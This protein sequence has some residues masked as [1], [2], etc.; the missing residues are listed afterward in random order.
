MCMQVGKYLF[1]KDKH[2]INR[3][4]TC[5]VLALLIKSWW[6]WCRTWRATFLVSRKLR[7][8]SLRGYLNVLVSMHF[9]ISSSQHWAL[10]PTVQSVIGSPTI[11]NHS[12]ALVMAVLKSCRGR[13]GGRAIHVVWVNSLSLIHGSHFYII[14]EAFID[15]FVSVTGTNCWYDE[16]TKLFPLNVSDVMNL[17][18]KIVTQSI[19]R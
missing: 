1:F 14:K 11:I 10:Y 6:C 3:R 8:S 13:E 4:V 2:S 19:N 17:Y 7:K 16:S 18:L 5:A 9:F 12:L 15:V